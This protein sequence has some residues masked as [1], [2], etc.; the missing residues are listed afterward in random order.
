M[1]VRFA[2]LLA[3]TLF[4]FFAGCKSKSEDVKPNGGNNGGGLLPPRATSVM[5][6]GYLPN[7]HF[8][9]SAYGDFDYSNLT[10][11]F[12][13]FISC[14]AD[15]DLITGGATN[16]TKM[17]TMVASAHTVNTKAYLCFGGGGTYGSQTYYDMARIESSRKEFAHQVKELC[18]SKGFDGFD[19]DWEGLRNSQDG[20]AHEAL[21]RTLKDT[22][23]S[24][25]LGLIV[26]VQQGSSATNFTKAAIDCA[27]LVQIMSYDATGSWNASP[28]GQHSSYEF[29]EAGV[30]YWAMN[31]GISKSKLVLGV[32]FYG[33]QFNSSNE[34]PC[35]AVTYKDIVATYPELVDGDDFIE[36]GAY[37]NTFFNGFRTITDKLNLARA[38]YM[39]GIMIW[40]LSQDATGSNAML[41]RFN[42]YLTS[43]GLTVKKL[44][45]S[46]P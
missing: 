43:N 27:D 34:C 2:T 32:P 20:A 14:T 39:P 12:Y 5:V 21:M 19:V 26:T 31:R 46:I 36:T 44:T 10:I 30:S 17:G 8:N 38:N 11:A 1:Q 40:E 23:H 9:N 16:E 42:N 41:T 24:V 3:A 45:N 28:Y 35:S 18:L 37:A 4:L 25:G 13:A 15:G 22:L 6:N 29:A 33:W 7:Y